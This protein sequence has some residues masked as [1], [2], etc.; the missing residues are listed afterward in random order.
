MDRTCSVCGNSY[1]AAGDASC[2]VCGHV[3]GTDEGARETPTLGG[4]A[5]RLLLASAAPVTLVCSVAPVVVLILGLI[6]TIEMAREESAGF[7]IATFLMTLVSALL[8]FCAGLTVHLLS[9]M[10]KRESTRGAGREVDQV[11]RFPPGGVSDG[12]T[13]T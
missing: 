2:P 13:T 7:A 12:G 9:L 3:A 4:A 5:S 10:L 6:A 1:S 11:R 8:C